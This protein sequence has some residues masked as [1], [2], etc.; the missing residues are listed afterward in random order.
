M[1]ERFVRWTREAEGNT[2]LKAR[3]SERT[4]CVQELDVADGS[5]YT[6]GLQVPQVYQVRASVFHPN[7][8]LLNCLFIFVASPATLPPKPEIFFKGSPSFFFFSSFELLILYW[9]FPGGSDSNKSACN[10]GY[11]SSIRGSGRSPGGGHGN[12]FQYSCLGNVM[13][14]GVWWATV[15]GITKSQAPFSD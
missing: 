12:P 7:P 1:R 6:D 8:V 13:D 5:I 15:H 3:R 4:R 9:R 2:Y 11:P 10:A 14:Q